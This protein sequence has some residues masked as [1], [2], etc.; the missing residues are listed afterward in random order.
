MLIPPNWKR[1]GHFMLPEARCVSKA[2][3]MTQATAARDAGLRMTSK[4]DPENLPGLLPLSAINLLSDAQVAGQG[5][6][7]GRVACPL[8]RGEVHGDGRLSFGRT[9]RCAL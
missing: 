9:E 7:M 6:G 4:L 5:R 3:V 2:C 8:A 1:N